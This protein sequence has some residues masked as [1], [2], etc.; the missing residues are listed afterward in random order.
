MKAFKESNKI[1]TY[2]T[3]AS[4]QQALRHGQFVPYFQP[5]VALS[6]GQLAGFEVLARWQHPRHGLV[7]PDQFISLAEKQGWID[8]LTEQLLRMAFAEAPSIPEPLTLSVNISPVQLRTSSLPGLIR[9]AAEGTDFSLT[10]LVIEIT[11]SALIDNLDHALSIAKE[12]KEMGCKLALDDFGTGYSS[13]LHLQALPFDELKVDRSFVSSMTERRDSR[14]IVAGVV[15]LGQSLGLRTVAEGI[16]TRDQAETMLWLGCELGQG[17]Y[18][19]RPLPAEDIASVIAIRRQELSVNAPSPWKDISSANLDG[20]LAQQ[21][22]NLQAVYDGAPVGLGF[23]DKNLRHV[24]INQRLADLDGL[25]VKDHLGRT[26]GELAS[27][28]AYSII[29][30][31]LQRALT[32][33]PITG[34]EVKM[35]SPYPGKGILTYNVSYQ[36]ARN[37][38]GQVIGIS[39][40][41]VDVTQNR[42]GEEALRQSEERYRNSMHLSPHTKWIADPKGINLEVSPMW[43]QITGQTPQQTA[44]AGLQAVMHPDDIATV[45]P[46][47]EKSLLTGE[48][49]DL[50]FRTR[51]RDGAWRWIRSRAQACRGIDGQISEWYGTAEDVNELKMFQLASQPATIPL[52]PLIASPAQPAIQVSV[53][54]TV[55]NDPAA[56][57]ASLLGSDWSG[58]RH[59]FESV[60]NGICISDVT[61]GDMPLIYVNPAFER[62]TG[63][64]LEEIRGRNCRFLQ[65]AEKSQRGLTLVRQA[66]H[67]RRDVTTV[68]KNFKKDETP[69]WNELHL[70]PIRDRTGSVTH[71]VGIQNDVTARIELEAK[72]ERTAHY[73]MLTGLA[74]RG[75]L[76]DRLAEALSRAE[77]SGRLV[78]V[79]F[80]DLD[81]LKSVNDSYGHDAGDLLIQT[82]GQRLAVS[83]RRHETAA[84]L[85]G[86]EFV[87]VLEDLKDEDDAANA[88]DRIAQ[89]VR[90]PIEA[91][92]N[93]I[94]S[95][96]SIGVAL[97]PRDGVTPA[98]LLRAADQ[99]M[100]AAKRT[101][102]RMES[103]T[104]T[105]GLLQ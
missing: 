92:Q 23:V 58:V 52:S 54:P 60:T 2:G 35:P 46:L 44:D 72:L 22:A 104:L 101:S 78:A 29:E 93:T 31:Y 39:I 16:E 18:F 84:R 32:G 75:L 90:Q 103:Y 64:R 95:S 102:K 27:P 51:T 77:R 21:V 14:K 76:M 8:T 7:S 3:A 5:I 24:N 100:Y 57:I 88:Q 11:E 19:G 43:E 55:E 91:S 80:L 96:A 87:V 73:D 30:P 83:I 10:R 6:S 4:A 79:L 33:E 99:A 89:D 26:I 45:M 12:L 9:N 38:A 28:I 37:E 17:W 1:V 15:G 70:S 53:Q 50:E 74:N 85:G 94:N 86:D 34:L 97:Y 67:D 49:M 40:A 65:G 59:I 62:L 20:S 82:V 13:L 41:V 105:S 42:R 98:S 36:P 71:Y 61:N 56:A 25:S 68:L 69:F 81:N 66:L 47:R 48:P 63:Y